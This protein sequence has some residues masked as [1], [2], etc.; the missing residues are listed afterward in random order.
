LGRTARNRVL[1]ALPV[2]CG[3]GRPPFYGEPA[4]HPGA[5]LQERTGWR[6]IQLHVRGHQRDTTCRVEGPYVREGLPDQ[7]VFLIVVKGIDRKIKGRRVRRDPVFYLVS[8]LQQSEQWV[9]PYS[10]EFLLTWAWQRWELEVQ[11]REIKSGFG[12]GEKQCWNPHAAVV[13]VQWS[14]WV[15]GTL[16][17]AGYRTWGLLGGPACPGNWWTGGKRWSFNTLWRA[18]RSALWQTPDFQALWMG[19]GDNWLQK[20]DWLSGMWNAVLGAARS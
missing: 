1:Y 19:S 17:L 6:T 13:S 3:K 8:A 18:Y 4:R 16:L 9:L 7:P 14:A 12:L 11:H 5:W 2:Y 20:G 10:V 15:Y